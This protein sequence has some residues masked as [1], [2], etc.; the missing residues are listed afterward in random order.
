V[1]GVELIKLDR[2]SDARGSLLAFGSE[3]LIPFDVGNVYFILDC[4]PSAVRAEH[5]TSGD[6][7]IIALS[8]SVTVDVD[9]GSERGSHLLSAPDTA[10]V[11]RAGVW[12]RLR[13]F[14]E[15]TRVVVL[16]SLPYAEMTHFDRPTPVLLEDAEP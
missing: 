4:P 8:P 11:V 3:S 5:A 9:N 14:S 12:L 13:E 15:E 6:S 10:L 2:Y 16:S 1:R 7:A